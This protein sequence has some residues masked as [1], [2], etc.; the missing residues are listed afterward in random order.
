MEPILVSTTLLIPEG[1]TEVVSIR[2]YLSGHSGIWD[3]DTNSVYFNYQ[4]WSEWK[5]CKNDQHLQKK[6]FDNL[7]RVS[8]SMLP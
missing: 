3:I 1:Q 8:K 4:L 2:F 7:R 6:F 5:D